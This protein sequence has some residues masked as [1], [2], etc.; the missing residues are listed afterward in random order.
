MGQWASRRGLTAALQGFTVWPGRQ[1][2]QIPSNHGHFN[3]VYVYSYL[4][5]CLLNSLLNVIFIN[6]EVFTYI[7]IQSIKTKN[8][9]QAIY[10]DLG[11]KKN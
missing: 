1:I 9:C 10:C 6:V 3:F 2:H 11:L 4:L 7:Q 5:R 8:P